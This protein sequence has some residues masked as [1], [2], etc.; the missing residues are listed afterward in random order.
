MKSFL[1][2]CYYQGVEAMDGMNADTVFELFS[3]VMAGQ[4]QLVPRLR[5]IV[6]KLTPHQVVEYLHLRCVI[7]DYHGP[8]PSTM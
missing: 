4:R 6:K 5:E 8:N 1:H 2:M 3:N 7:K